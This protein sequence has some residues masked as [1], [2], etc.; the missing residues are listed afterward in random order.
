MIENIY[1]Y[2]K[3]NQKRSWQGDEYLQQTCGES[4]ETST[5]SMSHTKTTKAVFDDAQ[6][7]YTKYQHKKKE[8]DKQ[9]TGKSK[10]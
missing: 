7:M 2:N 3:S 6:L 8:S 1:M 9:D 10:I 4:I 5:G